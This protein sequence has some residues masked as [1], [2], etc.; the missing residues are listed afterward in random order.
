MLR[1]K[2][3]SEQARLLDE[4][5]RAAVLELCGADPVAN[6][7][8]E[9]R[10]RALGADPLRLGAQ[11]W[12]FEQGGRLVSAC[13]SGANLAPVQATPA[14]IAAFA[15]RALRQG[16]RCSSLVGPS[17]AI[18]ELWGFLRPYWGP[19]RDVR[20]AQPLM[21]IDGPALV[22]PDPA[23]RRVRPDEID[24][25]LP[26]SIAMFTEEVGISPLSGDGGASYRAR[27]TELVR[28]GRALARIEDGRVIFKAEIGAATAQSCQVQG[29]WVR[30]EFR[31]R[32]LA[33]PGMAAVVGYAR[34]SI[35]PIVSL[36]VN[37]FNAAGRATYRRA[38][39]REVGEFMSVLF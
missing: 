15:D 33:A 27:V 14:A 20:S 18:R 22:P 21:A 13:Y 7:F 12:G 4:R 38:G 6:V 28:T 10:V 34:A 31:G 24:I 17:A 29:V 5:D 25:L 16:R 32:G 9:S 1:V 39:F 3:R 11:L 19:A 26:A 36:Y 30:P 2:Q 8:V 23:V 37:D 35:A